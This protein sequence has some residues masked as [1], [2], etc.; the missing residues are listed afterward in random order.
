MALVDSLVQLRLETDQ[1]STEHIQIRKIHGKETISQL[2]WFD[3]DI[4]CA[5]KGSELDVA[6]LVAAEACLVIE[7]RHAET[8]RIYGMIKA[9]DEHFDFEEDEVY[10]YKLR[11][12]PRAHRL[13]L[14]RMQDCYLDIAEPALV[15]QKL[16]K[17]DLGHLDVN[18]D[19]LIGSYPEREFIVQFAETDLAFVNRLTEHHGVSYFFDHDTGRDRVVFTDHND[20]FGHVDDC[21]TIS[22]HPRTDEV[23]VRQLRATTTAIPAHYVVMD[24]NY[25]T[26][27]ISL[28]TESHTEHGYA[29]GVCEWG[30]HFKT[31]DEAK[32]LATVRRQE[33]ESV[34]KVFRGESDV[35]HLS[36]GF[37]FAVEG[38]Q[39]L[40]GKE[41]LIVE[42]EHHG[43]QPVLIHGGE[44][45]GSDYT[46]TFVAIDAAQPYRPPRVTPRPRIPGLLTGVVEA[47]STTDV[48]RYA[49]VDDEGRYYI[50]FLFDTVPLGERRASRP[51]RRAYP[52]VGP[53]YGMH[54]PL[55]PGIEVVMAFVNGDP[56]RPIVLGAVHNTR[57]PNPVMAK[58]ART[59]MIKTTSG[60]RMRFKDD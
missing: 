14:V 34:H 4:V 54:F 30:G 1:F 32:S 28:T 58:I 56:D 43:S 45:E 23:G 59:N 17:V 8:R 39:K 25:R 51:V 42:V 35:H 13:E 18:L 57:T 47:K 2:F 50:K 31:Q 5:G 53:D 21:K 27:D 40:E 3:I 48:E 33:H 11:L 19:A 46:N 24:Y 26:P 9:V 38:H 44:E 52:N 10:A 36:A 37:R 7:H 20:G 15:R 6:D 29:G 55:R 49:R 60:I 41:L 22:L 16:E 12:V